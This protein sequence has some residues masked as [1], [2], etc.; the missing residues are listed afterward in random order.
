MQQGLLKTSVESV[1]F[2]MLYSSLS[3]IQTDFDGFS[4]KTKV[5]KQYNKNTPNQLNAPVKAFFKHFT[6][7]LEYIFYTKTMKY[8]K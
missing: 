6:T 1:F 4:I 5:K 3:N 2:R 8:K 7:I